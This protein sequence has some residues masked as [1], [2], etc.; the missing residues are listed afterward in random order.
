MR[1]PPRRQG[2]PSLQ[3]G[4]AGVSAAR[5]MQRR[6]V[7]RVM[8]LRRDPTRVLHPIYC[9]IPAARLVAEIGERV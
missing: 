4:I 7:V 8:R 5:L 9:R 1:F 3:S 2:C 6:I